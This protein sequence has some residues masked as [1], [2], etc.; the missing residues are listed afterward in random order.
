V[1]LFDRL[2]GGC[3]SAEDRARKAFYG[4]NRFGSQELLPLTSI[5][6]AIVE[7]EEQKDY[8]LLAET[9]A[10]LKKHAK[11]IPGSIFVKDRRAK[12]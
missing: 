11:A 3:F 9:A 7:C 6:L 12:K 5:T 8:G 10:Q 2:V 4:H 1:Q